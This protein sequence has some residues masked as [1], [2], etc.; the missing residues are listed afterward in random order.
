LV[1][2]Q[3]SPQEIAELLDV[4]DR[5]LKE[6]EISGLSPDWKLISPIMPL[7]KPQLQLSP[8]QDI[9]PK[10]RLIIIES[11]SRLLIPLRRVQH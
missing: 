9:G 8:Q 3:S 2:H 4:A 5:D 1:E 6:C 10:G 7:Y 11:F